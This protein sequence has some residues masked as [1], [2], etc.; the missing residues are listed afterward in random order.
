MQDIHKHFKKRKYLL[1]IVWRQ[2]ANRPPRTRGLPTGAGRARP[3]E[4]RKKVKESMISRNV[5]V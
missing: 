2:W 3:D 4:R 5:P 1:S